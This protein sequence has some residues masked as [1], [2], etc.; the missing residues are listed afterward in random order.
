MFTTILIWIVFGIISGSLTGLVIMKRGFDVLGD[1]F[2]GSLGGVGSGMVLGLLG[3]AATNW[4]VHIIGSLVGGI[5]L[6]SLIRPARR[7]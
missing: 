3:M 2:I 6:V 1:L 7:F 4:P 5:I